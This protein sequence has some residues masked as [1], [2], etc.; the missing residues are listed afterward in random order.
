MKLEMEH[1]TNHEPSHKHS[2]WKW[3]DAPGRSLAYAHMPVQVASEVQDKHFEEQNFGAAIVRGKPSSLERL[4]ET[5]VDERDHSE[6]L[7]SALAVGKI[8]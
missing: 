6:R 8:H 2:R 4:E 7:L 3:A 5:V 1:N